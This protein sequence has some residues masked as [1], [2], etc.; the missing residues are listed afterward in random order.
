M[1]YESN[2][3]NGILKGIGTIILLLILMFFIH[4]CSVSDSRNDRNMVYI[5]EG[6]CYDQDTNII[7][8]ESYSGRYGMDTTY[9]P[10]YNSNG[11]LCKYNVV[12][13][14]WIPIED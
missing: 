5:E 14:E 7:Y 6:Y 4:S 12:T 1:Y 3:D 11:D 9:S 10:Y 13:G 8:I 2:G